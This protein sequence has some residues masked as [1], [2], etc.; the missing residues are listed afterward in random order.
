LDP[1]APGTMR[2]GSAL[3]A[4][5]GLKAGDTV[6][7]LGREFEIAQV[8]DER[9]NSDDISV[10]IPLETAQE[11]LDRPDQLN[12][13]LALSCFCYGRNLDIVT[14]EVKNVLPEAQVIHRIPEAR[15]RILARGRAA[16]LTEQTT[17]S[18]AE[19]HARLAKERET[20]AA[21]LIPTVIV[22]ATIWIGLLAWGNVRERRAEIGILRALGLRSTQIIAVFLSKALLTGLV[23]AAVGYV[24]GFV[25]GVAWGS[26]E[27]V[28]VSAEMLAQLFD[29]LLFA[30][31]LV[32]APVQACLA[33][34]LPAILAA[35]QDPAVILAEE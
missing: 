31:V 29:P 11:L 15:I 22:V 21:W 23:G 1:V 13:I 17:S 19:Y 2:I 25:V 7:L 3:S 33:S 26:L 20:F 24:V 28:P 16:E 18:E 6:T 10:W 14:R 5:L 12:A 27:G 34:W 4:K 8:H 32:L 35:Q 30:G 9:G